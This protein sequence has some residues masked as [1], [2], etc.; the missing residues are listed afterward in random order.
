MTPLWAAIAAATRDQALDVDAV[1]SEVVCS[2]LASPPPGLEEVCIGR[3]KFDCT[4]D[5]GEDAEIVP[6]P[7]TEVS[8]AGRWARSSLLAASTKLPPVSRPPLRGARAPSD[9]LDKIHGSKVVRAYIGAKCQCV[10][11]SINNNSSPNGGFSSF[12]S[13]PNPNIYIYI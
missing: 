3:S 1:D 12:E 7:K 5:L 11:A 4:T 8:A 2:A 10:P 6:P 13:S 9:P